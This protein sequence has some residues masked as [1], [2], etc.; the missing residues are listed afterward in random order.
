MEE[1]CGIPM[2]YFD[3]VYSVYGIRYQLME[4]Y[5]HYQIENYLL[6]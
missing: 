1:D 3:I 4:V 5:Y 2:E 6:M